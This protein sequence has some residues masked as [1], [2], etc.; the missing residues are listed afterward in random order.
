VTKQ[1]DLCFKCHKPGH[2][3]RDCPH[4]RVEHKLVEAEA[5]AEAD[6]D[7]DPDSPESSSVTLDD[8][9]SSGEDSL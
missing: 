2:F 8:P 5:E 7:A 9:E 4:Q 3:G 6:A 1:D